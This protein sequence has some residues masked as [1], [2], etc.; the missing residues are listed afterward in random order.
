MGNTRKYHGNDDAPEAKPAATVIVVRDRPAGPEIYLMKRSRAAHFGGLHVFPGGKVDLAD[1]TT[2]LERF[3]PELS[4]ERASSTL[5]IE[6]GGL[7]YWVA[8]IRECFEECGLLLAYDKNGE[9][10]DT[11][12]TEKTKFE[13]YRGRMNSGEMG[14]L[15]EMCESEGLVLATERLAYF[16]H[17]ITPTVEKKRFDT[18]FFVAAAPRDQ[19][20]E[21]DGYETVDGAWLSPDDALQ[22]RN[23]DEIAMLPPT[24]KSIEAL[25][26]CLN[27]EEVMCVAKTRQEEGVPAILP[28][29][30]SEEGQIGLEL[31]P[32]G[33]V[34]R[35]DQDLLPGDS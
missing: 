13:Q 7:A 6:R 15:I 33:E 12:A 23:D 10:V 5:G 2:K 3:S 1:Q 19:R 4:D 32:T 35:D 31:S 29:V 18:R 26:H 34:V 20:A 14:V 27:A 16:A 24:F 9:F 25:S 22:K 28:Q 8:C 11:T 21:H 17:W 30:F